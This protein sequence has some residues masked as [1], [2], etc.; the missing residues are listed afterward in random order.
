MSLPTGF[1]AA[2]LL[3]PGEAAAKLRVHRSTVWAYMDRGMLPFVLFDVATSSVVALKNGEKQPKEG[4]FR[5]ITRDALA[6]FRKSY[7]QLPAVEKK[8][9]ERQKRRSK[10]VSTR[11]PASG[12]RSKKKAS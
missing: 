8:P 11:Q 5:G 6:E 3:S 12:R 10:S 9:K 1:K 4:V 7:V 2:G